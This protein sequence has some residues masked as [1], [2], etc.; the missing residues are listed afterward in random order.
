MQEKKKVRLQIIC[1]WWSSVDS[2]RYLYYSGSLMESTILFK[3]KVDSI[4]VLTRLNQECTGVW[5]ITCINHNTW[6]F[7]TDDHNNDLINRIYASWLHG[8][9]FEKKSVIFLWQTFCFCLFLICSSYSR[10]AWILADYI[11]EPPQ[12]DQVARAFREPG[13]MSRPHEEAQRPLTWALLM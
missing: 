1:M 9:V 2:H 6:P 8:P 11:F 7:L 13:Q 5:W 10:N 3:K 4:P 12:S